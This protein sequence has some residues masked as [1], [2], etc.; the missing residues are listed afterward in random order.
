MGIAKLRGRRRDL[1][2]LPAMRLERGGASANGLGVSMKVLRFAGRMKGTMDA[3]K[4][5]ASLVAPDPEPEPEPEVEPAAA[6]S[7][8]GGMAAIRFAGKAKAKLLASTKARAAAGHDRRSVVSLDKQ[9]QLVDEYLDQ[10]TVQTDLHY[11]V[12]SLNAARVLSQKHGK[13]EIQ[14]KALRVEERLRQQNPR[15]GMKIDLRAS[16]RVRVQIRRLWDLLLA[17]CATREEKGSK[18]VNAEGYYIIH[19]CI[20]KAVSGDGD[21]WSL[22]EAVE[23]AKQVRIY[24]YI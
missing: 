2:H 7:L 9:Q 4:V 1:T 22:S 15:L 5:T 16:A 12:S 3:A 10:I 8:A 23:V 11:I 20:S 24:I 6:P 18:T 21:N 14:E 17:E 13:S 19:C